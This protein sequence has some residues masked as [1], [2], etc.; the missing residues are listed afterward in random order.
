VVGH[1]NGT[2]KPPSRNSSLPYETTDLYNYGV[3]VNRFASHFAT[4]HWTKSYFCLPKPISSVGIPRQK[5]C[6]V[7]LCTFCIRV[8]ICFVW[9]GLSV[10]GCQEWGCTRLLV[11]KLGHTS[12]VPSVD[13][14]GTVCEEVPL[15]YGFEVVVWSEQHTWC[16]LMYNCVILSSAPGVSAENKWRAITRIDPR[17]RVLNYF[18]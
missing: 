12:L 6:L 16:L 10:I 7:L 18:L 13:E 11:G 15:E 2:N 4:V 1:L 14:L 9:C 3:L 8:L 5:L 17:S